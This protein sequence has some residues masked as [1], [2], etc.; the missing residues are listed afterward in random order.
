[1]GVLIDRFGPRK[2]L[3]AALVLCAFASLGFAHSESVLAA[4]IY[5]G[6]IGGA[7]AFGFV[8]TLTIA[9]YWF[10]STRFA[11]LSGILLAV[12]M[13]GAM[14]GQAPLRILVEQFGWRDTMVVLGVVGA[15][16]GVLL[17]LVVPNRP[18]DR[19][20]SAGHPRPLAGVK[21]VVTNP[22]SWMCAAIG[23]GLTGTLL[24]FSSLWAVPWLSTVR[25]F[26]VSEAAA[27]ASLVFLGWAVGSPI[28]G[29][30]SDHMGRRKPIIFAGVILSLATLCLIVYGGF[31]G[32]ATLAVLF[33][34]N[35]VGSCAMVI[36]FGAVREL[37][38]REN[39]GTALGLMNMFVVGSGAVLQPLIGWLLD[40]NWDG[41]LVE[42]ARVYD[43][44]A[45]AFA[46]T[47]LVGANLLALAC[48]FGL[49]ETFC[50]PLE[51]LIDPE[52]TAM[53]SQRPCTS[54]AGIA[55]FRTLN[56]TLDIQCRGSGP[57]GTQDCFPGPP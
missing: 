44:G 32:A 31:T 37:N 43:A 54:H 17:Y 51:D 56:P 46:F 39:S 21:A 13:L 4:S 7:V 55:R 57:C 3:S 29:W 18:G 24:A 30:A 23:F 35:G 38:R 2:L 52:R 22:Q 20:A 33:F 47:T 42:G 28:L 1:M 49:R 40:L 53:Y 8:G 6:L 11:L 9:T 10:P 27:I 50:R 41:Q 34:L 25:G 15:A 26:P 14:M 45:Y 5:R 12:G 36:C 48:G 16:L 19:A